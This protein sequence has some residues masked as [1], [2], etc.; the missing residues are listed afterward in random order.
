MLHC[1]NVIEEDSESGSKP[2]DDSVS[3]NQ[4]PKAHK[5][6]DDT[7]DGTVLGEAKQGNEKQLSRSYTSTELMS[8]TY[9]I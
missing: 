5:T 3:K 1:I 4:P 6:G 8:G 7:S 9:Y 2:N